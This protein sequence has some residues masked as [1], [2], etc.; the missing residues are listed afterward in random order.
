MFNEGY[1]RSS[2]DSL[3]DA[4]LTEEA[5]R[6]TRQ[7]QRALPDHDEVAGALALMLLTQARYAART[8]DLGDLI[9]LA[10]QDRLRWDG[11]LIAEGVGILERVLPR[12]HVG[13]FQL[14]AAIAA[15]HA[16]APTWADT[17]WLQI[18]MLYEML[19]RVAPSPAVTLNR[20]VAVAMT[21][22]PEDGLAIVDTLLA[23]PVMKRHHRTYAVRAHLLEMAGDRPGA[24]RDYERAARLTASLPEQRYLN[25]CC[26]TAGRRLTGDGSRVAAVRPRAAASPSS[27]ASA[28]PTFPVA[29]PRKFPGSQC[30]FPTYTWETGDPPPEVPGGGPPDMPAVLALAAEH[31]I[32]LLGPVPT[33][34]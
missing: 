29:L 31:G 8:D 4:S 5:I 34:E 6:L 30:G 15:V 32:E 19:E 13:R 17:D 3:V 7:L 28:L 22:G 25:A 9:R 18:T 24:A 27:R 10:D 33:P 14:Q 16:E 1:T 2:G 23:D 12:G 26:P 20:A 11:D 21:L